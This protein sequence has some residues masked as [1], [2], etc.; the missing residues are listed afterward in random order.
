MCELKEVVS[1]K[2]VKNHLHERE[3]SVE[4]RIKAYLRT[5]DGLF[6]WKEHGGMYSTCGI[7]DIIICYKGKFIALEVKNDVGRPTKLQL[8]QIDRIKRCGGVA[9]I[10]R[11]VDDAKA[12][13][14]SIS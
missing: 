1:N 12:V 7:P 8:I 9:T 14:E 3:K 6:Y 11:S 5:V 13:I 10:V 2:A 4:N